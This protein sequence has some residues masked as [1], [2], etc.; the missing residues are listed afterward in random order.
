MGVVGI[1]GRGDTDGRLCHTLSQGSELDNF[2][3]RFQNTC[4][5]RQGKDPEFGQGAPKRGYGVERGNE[6]TLHLTVKL[7]NS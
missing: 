5:G 3:C 4:G 7:R 2:W 6:N 1:G